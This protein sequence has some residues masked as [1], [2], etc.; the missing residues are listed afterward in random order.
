VTIALKNFIARDPNTMLTVGENQEKSYLALLCMF[1][2]RIL[3]VNRN[4]KDMI[5]GISVMNLIIAVLENMQGKIDNALPQFI[6]FLVEELKFVVEQGKKVSGQKYKSMI[7][8]A[9]SMCFSY[10]AQATFQFL[11]QQNLTL[12]VFQQWF[13]F[14]NDFKKDFEIRR[15]I[16][17]LT[18]IIKCPNLPALVNQ[19]LPD[20]MN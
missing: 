13:M 12:T 19:K 7:L 1:I 17:G 15:I 16:F 9:I 10:N 6:S 4:G 2:K 11:E 18:S 3:E 8:Q 5:D 20:V 14:M